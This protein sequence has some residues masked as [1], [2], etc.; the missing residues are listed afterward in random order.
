V[1]PG[2]RADQAF[3]RLCGITCPQDARGELG[4]HLLGPG[5]W[6][7]IAAHA[8]HHGF[9]GLV[10]RNLDWIREGT[11]FRAPILDALG[12][13][14]GRVL[15]QNLAR[16]AAARRMA[17]GLEL[18]RIP[19][20]VLKGVALAEETYGDL[21]LRGFNDFDVLV[22][23]EC[24]DAAYAVAAQLGYSL[25]RLGSVQEYVRYGAHAAGMAHRDGTSVDLHWAIAPDLR[26]PRSREI[27]WKDCVP[28]GSGAGL[29]GM[30]LGP[31]MALIHHAKHFHSHQYSILKP[32]VDFHV[33]RRVHRDEIDAAGVE[34]KA[35]AL[36]LL[37]VLGIVDAVARR[38]LGG[39]PEGRGVARFVSEELI[40]DS[41]N[42]PRV[43]NWVRFLLASGGLRASAASVA[44]ML[45]PS[46]LVIAQ[47]FNRP[48]S[49][50]LYPRY[51]WRQVVKVIT[52]STK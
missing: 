21:S 45:F 2:A 17:E 10:A 14:R 27:V 12:V 24:V 49:A 37:P 23:L 47:F 36:G 48:F 46:K 8:R 42:R 11:G 44:D 28:A 13:I 3:L 7:R 34:A 43:D 19:F 5:Q 20:A 41:E 29:P 25:T 52:L 31:E 32:L 33:T 15:T 6:E 30:R 22:P 50:R 26:D 38:S 51:Y 1:S 9:S 39:E 35:S 40:V 16:K 4:L 18:A